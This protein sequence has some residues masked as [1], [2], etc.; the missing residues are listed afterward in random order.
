[1]EVKTSTEI[2]GFLKK[3]EVAISCNVLIPKPIKCYLGSNGKIIVV[4]EHTTE[5]EELEE[6]DFCYE[7]EKVNW[8]KG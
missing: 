2:K 6:K 1:M 4:N 8:I 3:G 5:Y 7:Y